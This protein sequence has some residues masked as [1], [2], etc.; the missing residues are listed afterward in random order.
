MSFNEIIGHERPVS[1]LKRAIRNDALAHA[2]LFSGEEGIGKR[3]TAFALAAAIFCREPGSDGGCGA[4]PACRKVAAAVHPDIRV[5]MPES[6]DERLLATLSSKEIEKASDAIKIDQIRQAQEAISLRP[7]EGSKKVLIVDGAEAMN[8]A[9]ANAFLKTLEEPPGDSLIM[10]ISAMPQGLLPTIRSR[11]QEVKFQPLSRPLLAAVLR[12]K[13]GLSEEDAW[14]LAALSR[15]SLGRALG[16]DAAQ[17][18]A[19]REEFLALVDSLGG[20]SEDAIL[21]RAETVSKD[22][23]GLMRLLDLGVERVRDVLVYQA[24]HEERL[25]VFTGGGSRTR[26]LAGRFSHQ[27]M[28]GDLET[29]TTSR[30]LLERRVSA[31]LVAEKLFLNFG[32]G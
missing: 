18:R 21:S 30:A 5:V 10:L 6:E 4:C 20:M 8:D 9:S 14:F 2:Y 22:R 19:D 32:R 17:E 28:F 7:S 15:G 25:L 12:D 26:E 3:M 13:R 31:Q 29:L 1:I 27:Q 24:T 11:C 23:D 16:M